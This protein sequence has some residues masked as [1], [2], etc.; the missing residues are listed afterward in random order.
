MTSRVSQQI[1]RRGTSTTGVGLAVAGVCQPQRSYH[2]P[3]HTPHLVCR[4]PDSCSVLNS[5]THWMS[6]PPWSQQAA[7]WAWSTCAGANRQPSHRRWCWAN[8]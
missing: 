4:S 5:P 7:S 6:Q 8:V 1:R 3:K 2:L